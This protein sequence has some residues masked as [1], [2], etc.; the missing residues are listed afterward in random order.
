MPKMSVIT[1]KA[2]EPNEEV[3]YFAMKT[4]ELKAVRM[5]ILGIAVDFNENLETFRVEKL[6]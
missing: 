6:I 3:Q 1:S 5:D 2:I 4:I